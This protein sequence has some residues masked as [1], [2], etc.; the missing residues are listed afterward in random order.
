MTKGN[1]FISSEVLCLRGDQDFRGDHDA[2]VSDKSKKNDKI[3]FYHYEN[4]IKQLKFFSKMTEFIS[5]NNFYKQIIYNHFSDWAI[6]ILYSNFMKQKYGNPNFKT[7]QKIKCINGIGLYF[8]LNLI[9][10]KM[11]LYLKNII[12]M[13]LFWEYLKKL[14]EKPN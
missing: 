5:L 11:I 10:Y 14:F 3:P 8:R 6:K 7:L 1:C 9:R 2:F 4:R 12:K 13:L